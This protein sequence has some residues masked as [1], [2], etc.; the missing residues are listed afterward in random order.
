MNIMQ[1]VDGKKNYIFAAALFAIGLWN[2]AMPDKAI[3]IMN[4]S[5][6]QDYFAAAAGWALARNAIA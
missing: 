5:A 6:P 2:A 4:L 3:D 1:L